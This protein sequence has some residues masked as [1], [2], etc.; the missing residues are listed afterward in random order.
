[1]L[2]LRQLSRSR[3]RINVRLLSEQAD[4]GKALPLACL[5]AVLRVD[6]F[7]VTELEFAAARRT[8]NTWES[9]KH[10]AG[11]HRGSNSSFLFGRSTYLVSIQGG[12][13]RQE[14]AQGEENLTR[15]AA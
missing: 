7:F 10:F 12:A 8:G 1:M 9:S 2:K 11:F 14:H 15:A 13:L 3:E 5:R 4:I 6:L